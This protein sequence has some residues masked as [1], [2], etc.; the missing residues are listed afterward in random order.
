MWIS[1]I[2]I[3]SNVECEIF[4]KLVYLQTWITFWIAKNV[5]YLLMHFQSFINSLNSCLKICIISPVFD[6]N[7]K[8]LFPRNY[9]TSNC[10]LFYFHQSLFDIDH[11]TWSKETKQKTDLRYQKIGEPNSHNKSVLLLPTFLAYNWQEANKS[12]KKEETLLT[13]YTRCKMCI[14]RHYSRCWS[15][16]WS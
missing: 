14:S 5:H 4:L 15:R 9:H 8:H 16:L 12:E 2:L 10:I 6:H 3:L 7:A 1:L 11:V 13:Y